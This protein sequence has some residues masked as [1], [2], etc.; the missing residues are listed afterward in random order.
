M[1]TKGWKT[2]K[3]VADELGLTPAY[4][5]MLKHGNAAITANVICRIAVLTG[6][7]SDNWWIFFRL[8]PCGVKDQNHPLWNHEK[9][10]GRVPY[11]KYSLSA[12]VR[13][14]DY[15][16]EQVGREIPKTRPENYF[17]K[18]VDKRKAQA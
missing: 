14:Q 6:N 12:E 3:R 13:K 11:D 9:E 18:S 4:V 8:V 10:M 1:Q 15:F 17:K 2:F 7:V 5:T 16:V